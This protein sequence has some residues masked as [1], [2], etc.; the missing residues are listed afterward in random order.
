MKR[1]RGG[2]SEN[3]RENDR[4]QTRV[5]ETAETARE[6]VK[7]RRNRER[8]I[9]VRREADVA[10][11]A[12]NE[13]EIGDGRPT[14][15]ERERGVGDPNG[16]AGGGGELAEVGVGN[17]WGG[18]FGGDVDGFADFDAWEEREA[19][20]GDRNDGGEEEE[21]ER[22]RVE[23]PFANRAFRSGNEN[24]DERRGETERERGGEKTRRGGGRIGFDGLSGG[25]DGTAAVGAV[26]R[27][28]S[29]RE[30]GTRRRRKVGANW[31]G[32][33]G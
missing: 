8:P 24:R 10:G 21:K 19:E 29:G 5:E 28:D 4:R 23:V 3:Q 7:E 2:A 32:R 9:S 6:E 11:F 15:E 12:A 30:K 25:W 1:L 18:G 27:K 26:H 22:D 20:R 31:L 33:D 14:E 13:R 17:V 16:A